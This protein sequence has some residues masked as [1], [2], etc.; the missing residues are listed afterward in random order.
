VTIAAAG[1]PG[2]ASHSTSAT[3]TFTSAPTP[4][5]PSVLLVPSDSATIGQVVSVTVTVSNSD[6][7]NINFTLQ[8][9][10]GSVT[11]VQMNE[12][13]PAN[14]QKSFSLSWDTTGFGAGANTVSVVIFNDGSWSVTS[15]GSSYSLV[16]P[17]P[18]FFTSTTIA[19][20]G[21]VLAAV[22]VLAIF[23]G[24]RLRKKTPVV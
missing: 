21:G 20:I 4:T 2:S 12:T 23:L 7:V 22:A 9:K 18:P 24:L 3:F 15:T 19:V 8:V 13:L 14:Q 16:A 10:W 6:G 17:T 5:I 1:T 11:V